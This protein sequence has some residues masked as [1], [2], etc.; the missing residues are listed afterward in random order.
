[1]D[2]L[3]A[4]LKK[5][6]IPAPNR[7]I[8][9]F[10]IVRWGKNKRYWLRKFDDGYIFGDFVNGISSHVFNRDY[11]GK[12]LEQAVNKMRQIRQEA[13]IELQQVHEHAAQAENT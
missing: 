10:R 3:F 1:M 9:S 8:E 5:A 11:R 13:E 7:D 2:K 4:P 6:D 12:Q